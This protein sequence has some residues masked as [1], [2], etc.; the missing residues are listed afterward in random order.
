A[1]GFHA[2]CCRQ[3]S[4]P[5][6]LQPRPGL[7]PAT[8]GRCAQAPGAP[9]G[10][11]TAHPNGPQQDLFGA[12]GNGSGGGSRGGRGRKRSDGPADQG[13]RPQLPPRGGPRAELPG[14]EPQSRTPGWADQAPLSRA[15]LD[16]PRGH[17]EQGPGS[18]AEMPRVDD[19][20][21]AVTGEFQRPEL[22]GAGNSAQQTGQFARPD[23][24]Q[25]T[26]RFA[27]PDNGR[28]A[29]GFPQPDNAQQT[30]QFPQL[31][32][33]RQAGGFPQLDNARHTGQFA[34]P[35]AERQ[36][37]P[38]D[39]PGARQDT[40]SFARSDVFGA[41]GSGRPDNGGRHTGQFPAPQAPQA[42]DGGY[43]GGST[44]QHALPGRPD[45]G[46]TGQFERPR[47]A[48]HEDFGAPH[49][50]APQQQRPARTEPEALPPASGPGDGRT[51]LFDTLETNWF[52]QQQE[53][54]PAPQQNQ[55]QTQPQSP[56][57]APQRSGS[58][59]GS[60]RTSPNDELV[61]QAE[62]VRQPAAGGVTT[63]G[64]PRRV[65]RA[66]L[67]PGTAQQQQHQSG[68]QVSRAP[69]DVR[70]RLTNLRRGIAQGRQAGSGQTGSFPSPTH[71]QER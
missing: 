53:N 46:H 22:P 67:V 17:D 47:P 51:P 55:P 64:L 15:S 44:G 58:N 18:T 39:A 9:Q 24:L 16:T 33:G 32:N 23:D 4:G 29:G 11:Q 41:P 66:N 30:G 48:G 60:W 8:R 7:L 35:D 71:Q 37:G 49:P 69:D 6:R 57:S 21:P 25:Q 59:T 14:S 38:F 26:G 2:H 65:P 54:A 10:L 5:G 63:S 68:P 36:A 31:D 40:G 3:R 56:A 61:R 1:Y 19:R 28:Q 45:P 20:G 13:R 70:G 62:R 50:A 12:G 34:R 52:Q 43:D 42:Y 27:Q